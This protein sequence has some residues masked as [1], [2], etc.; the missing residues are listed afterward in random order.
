[1]PYL[2]V[3]G[4]AS[5]LALPA[6][7]PRVGTRLRGQTRYAG[8]GI[9]SD[10]TWITPTKMEPDRR[11]VRLTSNRKSRHRQRELV[12]ALFDRF[13]VTIINPKGF[14]LDSRLFDTLLEADAF[15]NEAWNLYGT[16]KGYRIIIT[17]RIAPVTR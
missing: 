13:I 10:V 14:T 3:F 12:M 17:D 5:A 6:L 9:R 8:P 11:S 16:D 4:Q 2:I 7:S 1:M 15:A